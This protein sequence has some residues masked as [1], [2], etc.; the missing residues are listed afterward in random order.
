M[1]LLIIKNVQNV[2]NVTGPKD[3]STGRIVLSVS[4]LYSL[5][6]K[7]T[8]CFFRGRKIQKFII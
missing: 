4:N 2:S 1:I 6:N 7:M 8:I 5:T 3:Y